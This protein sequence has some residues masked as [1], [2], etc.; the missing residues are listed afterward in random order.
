[1]K[2]KQKK[3][4]RERKVFL[5]TRQRLVGSLMAFAMSFALLLLPLDAYAYDADTYEVDPSEFIWYVDNDI[6]HANDVL[7][8]MYLLVQPNSQY[9]NGGGQW[10]YSFWCDEGYFD[11]GDGWL[12]DHAS[13]MFEFNAAN[14]KVV[15]SLSEGDIWTW[16]FGIEE[17]SY[18]FA[19]PNGTSNIS[20]LP[21]S[22]GSP[23]TDDGYTEADIVS[24]TKGETVVLY[25]VYGDW[26]WR[27][28]NWT[29]IQAWAKDH[30]AAL[31]N[32]RTNVGTEV[33]SEETIT[34][35]QDATP[36]PQV[37]EGELEVL[38]TEDTQ[39][40]ASVASEAET[41]IADKENTVVEEKESPLKTILISGPIVLVLLIACFAIKK[42]DEDK[43]PEKTQ[44]SDKESTK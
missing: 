17:G 26:N 20:I 30:D 44:N 8:I 3:M 14:K 2:R 4:K 35:K 43:L 34:V 9:D 42:K 12:E 16:Q 19:Y 37:S 27:Q 18:E 15:E 33:T 41:T 10:H 38:E 24:V 25:G 5:L 28:E 11:Y 23:L 29:A 39:E 40:E 21:T 6:A 1:M 36:E 22:L 13:M 32:G 7:V 31:N